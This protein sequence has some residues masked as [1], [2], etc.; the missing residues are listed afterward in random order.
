[1]VKRCPKVDFLAIGHLTH[2]VV[3][4]GFILGGASAYSSK[5]AFKLGL[6]V[7]VVSAVGDDFLHYDKLDG[8]SLALVDRKGS[9]TTTFENIYENG[10]RRQVIRGVAPAIS[11]MDVPDEWKDAK[12]VYICPVADEVELSI[13]DLFN[14]SLIGASPQGWMRRWN[15]KG[16][17]YPKKW[18]LNCD[19]I[20]VLIMSEE[21]IMPFPQVVGEYVDKVK[22]MVL[23]R[24]ENGSRLFMNG[25]IEDFPAFRT[26]VSDPTGAG[27]VFAAAFLIKYFE[28]ND[29]VE[30]SI[31][32]NCTASFVVEKQGMDGIPDINLVNERVE[33]YR[34]RYGYVKRC[35]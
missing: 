20:D 17:V 22:I 12:I 25:T 29:P 30:A 14:S 28:T 3:N 34:N 27:D 10:I 16:L 33:L 23:T 35:L 11:Q 21:D 26:S 15:D 1:M 32:A 8:I 4:N 18:E 2:D 13:A 9:K 24:G 31:F 7:G 6:K 5:T 19:S